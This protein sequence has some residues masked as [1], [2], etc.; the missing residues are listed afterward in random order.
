MEEDCFDRLTD[1]LLLVI[2]NKL[3]DA[4][5]LTRCVSVSKRFASLVFEADTVFLSIP[6]RKHPLRRNLFKILIGKLIAKPL[7][8]FHHFIADRPD[9]NRKA[10]SFYLPKEVLKQF[11]QVKTMH[12]ELPSDGGKTGLM[13]GNDSLLKWKARFGSEIKNFVILSATSFQKRVRPLSSDDFSENNGEVLTDGQLKLQIVLTISCLLA[14]SARHY[15]MKQVLEEHHALENMI[16]SDVCKQ[17]KVCMGKDE[18]AEIRNSMK[19]MVATDSSLERTRVPDLSM[20]LWYVPLLE[21]PENGYIM[22]GATLVVL[23]PN[24]DGQIGNGRKSGL[25]DFDGEECEKKAYSEAAR[26]MMKMKKSYR[27]TMESF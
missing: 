25:F 4:K 26:E 1:D 7:H 13:E 11:R 24:D 19:S 23:R 2:F 3:G 6:P 14:A 17:G 18:V 22:R 21:L 12:I 15:L 27:M 9:T 16:A 20:K 10:V 8:F 5:S